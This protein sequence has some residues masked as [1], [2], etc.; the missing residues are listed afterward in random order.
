[1]SSSNVFW[2]IISEIEI[3]KII[4]VNGLSVYIWP[5]YESLFFLI[6]MTKKYLI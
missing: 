4:K 6:L 5:K 3:L 2:K 1:M